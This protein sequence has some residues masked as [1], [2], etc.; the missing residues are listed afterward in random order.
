MRT[1]AA[2]GI[3]LSAAAPQVPPDPAKPVPAHP[4]VDQEKVDEAIRKGCAFLVSSGGAFG[5][6]PH[7]KRNQ[8]EALQSYAELVLLTLAHSGYYADG[9]PALQPLV[10]YVLQK[11]IGSTYTASLMAMALQK[12]NAR[13]YQARIAQCA[14]FLVDN[15]CQ[16]GQWD[17][18]EPLPPE[19]GKP[20][21]T[22]TTSGGRKEP[23]DVA[24]GGSSGAGG[25][26]PR[27]PGATSSR[28]GKTEPLRK[29]SIRKRRP[30][31]LA[32]DNSNS[33][34]AALGLRAC[35]EAGCDIEARVLQAARRW[36]VGSQNS[37][38]GWGYN[39]DGSQG[40][41]DNETGVSN[42][43]YGSMTVG[44]VGALCIYDYY[45]GINYKADSSVQRGLEWIVKNY[46]VTA[47]PRKK[48]FAYLY[49]LYGLER[50][51][52]L[53]GAEQFGPHEWY[54]DGANH[55][56]KTQNPFGFWDPGDRL[57][58]QVNVN[59]C[60]AILF[61]RRGT[62]PLR[63][64]AVATG[65]AAPRGGAPV[66]NPGV[67]GPAEP[68]A[69]AGGLS[70]QARAVREFA[71]GWKLVNSARTPMTERLVEVRGR[72]GV[73]V[74]APPN[75]ET[76]PTLRRTVE[77]AGGVK[78]TLRAVVGY[79]DGGEWTLAVNVEGREVLSRPVNPRTAPG[80]W[81]EVSVDLTPHAGKAVLVELVNRPGGVG[82]ELAYWA[83]V[84]IREE[85][86]GK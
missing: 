28:P 81:L 7:G 51:G 25:S 15:Q 31:P 18:G 37:D 72:S 35:I 13:K 55:L 56:L 29:I 86:I 10:E 42:T 62:A 24:T 11:P 49:Y 36:W 21:D 64:E 12:L 61:L 47:N 68:Q 44:A 23:E 4:K 58:S 66:A 80:G 19:P 2:L 16:N 60:F 53:Y 63:R 33:Q 67:P 65:G 40:G 17:Y 57:P 69:G 30:G 3:L 5:T 34:Y 50:V 1:F 70:G 83:E 71:P 48:N 39:G 85:P 9:D 54:P 41:E 27:P 14:Q 38:G 43:S 52:M 79:P 6:F 75:L 84:S 76:A 46:D 32:G 20:A 78:T 26:G 77:V 73:L 22:A 8:P 82:V 45:L 59:T 74:T